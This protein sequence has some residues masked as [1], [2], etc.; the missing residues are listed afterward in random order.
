VKAAIAAIDEHAWTP[1]EYTDAVYDDT[2]ER[3]ISRAEVA[4]IEPAAGGGRIGRG[5]PDGG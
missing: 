5:H 2:T 3:W 4:E 1:I